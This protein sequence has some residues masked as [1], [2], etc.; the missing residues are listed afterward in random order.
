MAALAGPAGGAVT[1]PAGIGPRLDAVGAL[2]R[3]GRAAGVLRDL[4]GAGPPTWKRALG[5]LGPR[6]RR[7]R[8]PNRAVG[9]RTSLG[10]GRR[11]P[12]AAGR[13]TLRTPAPEVNLPSPWPT[14]AKL[15]RGHVGPGIDSG[16]AGAGRRACRRSARERTDIVA[17][18][19]TSARPGLSLRP[20]G[21]ESPAA[22]R[23][24]AGEITLAGDRSGPQRSGTNNVLR[25]T[26]FRGDAGRNCPDKNWRRRPLRSD[27]SHLERWPAAVR[28]TSVVAER[29]WTLDQLE[30]LGS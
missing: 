9:A 21:D 17:A 12:A 10:P 26:I 1:D 18:P 13:A 27:L 4:L 16:G 22:D 7:G 2:V 5:R 28:F 30:V 15:G 3:R 24:V 6:P 8:G 25:L 20:A 11:G 23:R 29:G 19:A 14:W